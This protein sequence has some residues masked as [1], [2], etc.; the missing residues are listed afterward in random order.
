M[1]NYGNGWYRC[2][3][4]PTTTV[5]G[6]DAFIIGI[7]N[8]PNGTNGVSGSTIYFWGAQLETG[9]VATSYIPTTTGSI[10]RNA[11]VVSVSGAVSGSIGQA[12]GTIYAEVDIRNI[13][14]G[15]NI[16]S[17][18]DGSTSNRVSLFVDS[19]PNR[20]TAVITSGGTGTIVSGSVTTGVHKIAVSYSSGDVQVF[21]N[22]GFLVSGIPTLF[23]SVTRNNLSIGGRILSGVYGASLN[24][25]IRAVALYTT[26]LTNDQLAALTSP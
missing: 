22:G 8:A 6:S 14:A 12:S 15:K 10:T 1:Q 23:P 25:R 5:S 18:D 17:T 24:D 13:T 19:S 2:I 20:L 3:F 9:S 26:R 16:I 7:S 4:T 21:L 11:D